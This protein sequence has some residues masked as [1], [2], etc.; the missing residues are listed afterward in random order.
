MKPFQPLIS[1]ALA[2]AIIFTACTSG[3]SDKASAGNTDTTAATASNAVD[4]N[5]QKLEDNKKLVTEFY[6]SLYGDKDSTAIDKYVADNI[7]EHNPLLQDGKDWLKNSLRPFLAN[8]NIE[9]TKVDIKQVAADGDKV[10]L[11]VRDVAPNGK[12]FARVN[13][14]RVENGKIAEA[15]KVSESVPAKSANKNTMF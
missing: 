11:L 12:E 6:Q 9:K 3:T 13:I 2:V 7:V 5:Q 14:F 10:W 4:M 15:W 1:A 8:P